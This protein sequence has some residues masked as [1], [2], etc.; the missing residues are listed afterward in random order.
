MTLFRESKAREGLVR[1]RL[2]RE[3]C[4]KCVGSLMKLQVTL[5][6]YKSKQYAPERAC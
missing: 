5:S 2:A 4:T 1:V 6:A 3:V